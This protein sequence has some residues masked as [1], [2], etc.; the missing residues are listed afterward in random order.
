MT[1]LRP[2]VSV[3]EGHACMDVH[4]LTN[5][6]KESSAC[7]SYGVAESQHALGKDYDVLLSG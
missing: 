4:A 5:V 3:K 2:G 1:R 7:K 6:E